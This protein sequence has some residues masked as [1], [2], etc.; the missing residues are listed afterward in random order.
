MWSAK[1]KFGDVVRSKMTAKELKN[2]ISKNRGYSYYKEIKRT[3][4]EIFAYCCFASAAIILLIL[5]WTR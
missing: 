4:A 5:L 3:N 1:N 2:F